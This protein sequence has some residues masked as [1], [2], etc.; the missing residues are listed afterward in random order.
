MAPRTRKASTCANASVTSEMQ[1]CAPWGTNN[2]PDSDCVE[3]V[4]KVV[5]LLSLP[6][7][8]LG[9]A[10]LKLSC[11]SAAS[12]VSPL[13]SLVVHVHVLVRWSRQL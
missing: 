2:M 1:R 10:S 3:I 9:V 8:D 13:W 7:T 6:G 11:R 4:D 5:L 12:A